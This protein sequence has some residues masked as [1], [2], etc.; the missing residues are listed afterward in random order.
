MN[1]NIGLFGPGTV[2]KGVIDI[3]EKNKSKLLENYNINFNI[4]KNIC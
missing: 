4:T 3:I 1:I 2:G